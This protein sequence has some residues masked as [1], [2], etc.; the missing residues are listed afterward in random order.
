MTA[1]ERENV[2]KEKNILCDVTG[3]ERGVYSMNN[4]LCLTHHTRFKRYGRLDNKLG[5]PSDITIKD[6]IAYIHLYNDKFAKISPED[7]DKV[8]PY[9]WGYSYSNGVVTQK[10][11]KYKNKHIKL[12]RMILNPSKNK[13]IDHINGDKLDNRRENLRIVEH[14]DN[15]VNQKSRPMRNI[16]KVNHAN[17]YYVRIRYKNKKYYIGYF[18]SLKDAMSARD[19]AAKEI[20]GEYRSR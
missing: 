20:H 14:S 16:T 13:I 12:H 9:K 6:G 11:S 17:G 7:I 1:L 10:Q 5:K 2:R 18:L 19:K 3:C 8:K 15:I 4:N